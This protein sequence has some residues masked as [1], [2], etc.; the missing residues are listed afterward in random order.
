MQQQ[1]QQ[2]HQQLATPMQQL[3]EQAQGQVQDQNQG[4]VTPMDIDGPAE[5]VGGDRVQGGEA[6]GEQPM[7]EVQDHQ[8][9]QQGPQH[10]GPSTSARE[11][12]SGQQGESRA[13]RNA[14]KRPPR[15]LSEEQIMERQ[16]MAEGSCVGKCQWAAKKVLKELTRHRGWAAGTVEQARLGE[17]VK[18]QEKQQLPGM[19]VVV[20]GNTGA[21]K[22]TLLN[23]LIGER[24]A[25][26]TNGMRACTAVLAELSYADDV[27]GYYGE[28]EFLTHAEWEKELDD[29]L[30]LLTQQDGRAVLN[31]DQDAHNYGAWAKLYAIYGERYTFSREVTGR[32]PDGRLQYKNM[33]VADLRRKLLRSGVARN[34]LGT[35]Q[36]VRNRDVNLF[37]RSMEQFVDSRNSDAPGQLWPLV[38]MVRMRSNKWTTLRTGAKIVDA[39]GVRDDNRA[40]DG[41]V[42][43]FL[44]EADSI[45]IVSHINRAAN[46]KT[47]KD[48]MGESFRRQLLMDGQ[49]DS[50]V[51][52]ATQSDSLVKTEI[53]RNLKLAPDASA[54]EVATA[55]NAFIKA[56]LQQD[57]LDGLE[58][59]LIMSG[60]HH[61]NS[62]AELAARFQLPVYTISATDFQKLAGIRLQDGPPQVWG[63]ISGTEIPALRQMVHTQTLDR[64]RANIR[65]QVEGLIH[66]V[67]GIKAAL[68]LGQQD[69]DEGGAADVRNK[70]RAAFDSALEGLQKQLHKSVDEFIDTV[71]ATFAGAVGP[72]LEEGAKTATGEVVNI[73]KSWGVHKNMHWAT[74]KAH[75]RRDGEYSRNMNEEMAEPVYRAV[76]T[77]WERAFVG[78]LRL[79]L[80][81]VKKSCNASL[82]K[83]KQEVS[84]AGGDPSHADTSLSQTQ[85]ALQQQV[86]A[87]ADQAQRSSLATMATAVDGA[88]EHANKQQRDINRLI[89]PE[90]KQQM[91]PAYQAGYAEHGTG[92]SY[93]RKD[94]MER[95]VH[96]HRV[97]MFKNAILP[98]T[99]GLKQL[100]QELRSKL[101]AGVKAAIQEVQLSY[102]ALWGESGIAERA[103]CAALLPGVSLVR[104]EAR[105]ALLELL[106]AQGMELPEEFKAAGDEDGDIEVL[107][108][109]DKNDAAGGSDE[110]TESEDEEEAAFF[111][112]MAEREQREGGGAGGSS[113]RRD[114]V[115]H[116]MRKVAVQSAEV[117]DLCD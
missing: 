111:A 18:L 63:D 10:A 110:C 88:C 39:P 49:M 51:F 90:I 67:S 54:E 35:T 78:T 74:Y 25:L 102:S 47:A 101:M 114:G 92:S 57:F 96:H 85:L 50:L 112:R 28:V 26:P 100:L 22:S 94:I 41:V 56:R 99:Q 43:K 61:E 87:L 45:W 69:K 59:M 21:G 73:V 65:K 117:I 44:K 104:Q 15:Q 109:N 105:R 29:L 31:V 60:E 93:R 52:I 55:R 19:S 115:K 77:Y 81:D 11:G 7:A 1:Q 38:R 33:F 86:V 37:R 42:K 27:D 14:A 3:Q 98:I 13:A 80:Q 34:Y 46:D 106:Q 83:F 70:M 17:L 4:L 32:T 40:R 79:Q 72:Q 97:A 84:Q 8:Q 76:S 23:A 75:C 53:A 66:F 9:Q 30:E 2:Q 36:I 107:E 62:R 24:N 6:Q 113:S 12:D 82:Q 71:G 68:E 95:H 103:K 116:G 58:E 91:L 48:L 16:L 64:R 108:D 20:V 89:T 5:D